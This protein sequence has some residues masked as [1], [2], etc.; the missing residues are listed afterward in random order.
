MNGEDDALISILNVI[1]VVLKLKNK[2]EE[3]VCVC[4]WH[5]SNYGK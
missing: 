4:K 3:N 1:M 2:K 5:A